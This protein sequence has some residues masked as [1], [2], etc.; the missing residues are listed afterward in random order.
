MEIIKQVIGME[1]DKEEISLLGNYAPCGEIKTVCKRLRVGEPENP[2]ECISYNIDVRK[3]DCPNAETM[4]NME[5]RASL[6]SIL[7]MECILPNQM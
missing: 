4:L 7:E 2:G 1:M 6:I 3:C 5:G